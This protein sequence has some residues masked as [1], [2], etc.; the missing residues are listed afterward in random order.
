MSNPSS[1]DRALQIFHCHRSRREAQQQTHARVL[2][3]Q[4]GRRDVA[5]PNKL[6]EQ[7]QRDLVLPRRKIDLEPE[8]EVRLCGACGHG[9]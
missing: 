5:E 7:A 3:Q 1:H 6:S 2:A 4:R 8:P 9:E